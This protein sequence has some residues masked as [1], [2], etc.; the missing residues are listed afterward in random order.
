MAFQH[1]APNGVMYNLH[2]MVVKL[3]GSGLRQ[4]IFWFSTKAGKDAIDEMP[5][6]YKIVTSRKTGLPFLKKG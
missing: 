4:K 6:G 1:K 3:K 5:E 2:S